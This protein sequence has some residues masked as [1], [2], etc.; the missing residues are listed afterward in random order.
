[1]RISVIFTF[2]TDHFHGICN[3]ITGLDEFFSYKML[4]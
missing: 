4:L 2:V 1:M 3:H